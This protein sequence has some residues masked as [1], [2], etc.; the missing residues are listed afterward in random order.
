MS[1]QGKLNHY[2]AQLDK[3]LSN[4]PALNKIEK[5]I[6]VPKAYAVLG[7]GGVFA[8]AIF[9][10]IFAGF[11]TTLLGWALPAYLSLQS[12]ESPSS[13]DDVQW[14]TY[15]TVFSTFNILEIFSDILLYWFP[16]YYT[17]KCVFIVW[18]ML[19]QTRGAQVLYHK[20]LK[21]LVA[22]PNSKTAAPETAP[23]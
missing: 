1:V 6:Q 23:Q 2:V 4:Y 14:L 15:W 12:L 19:P 11:L 17:F 16:F 18:L 3:E 20:A 8:L 22:N 13:G 10:N 21:P 7:L 5:Q 9:F